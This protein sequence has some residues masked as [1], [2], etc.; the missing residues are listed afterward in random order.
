MSALSGL[1]GALGSVIGY[2]GAE[3]AEPL[4]FER[5]LWPQRFYNDLTLAV[6][7]KQ[8]IFMTMGGPLHRAAL[9]TLDV[10]RDNG[11][12]LGA[13]RGNLL[14]TAFL[15]DSGVQ[16]YWHSASSRKGQELVKEARN[17]FWVE[18]LRNVKHAREQS[19]P[20]KLDNEESKNVVPRRAMQ[21]VYFLTLSLAGKDEKAKSGSV[22]ISEASTTWK[23]I[24][25]LFCSEVTA[26]AAAIIAGMAFKCW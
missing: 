20:I 14:G 5:L 3:V 26:I 15:R 12:Y 8:S 11:L 19:L 17:G 13:R 16:Y 6:L 9:E 25:L 7:I 22:Q 4:I 1:V 23:T 21:L 18:V 24:C 2:L 10:L